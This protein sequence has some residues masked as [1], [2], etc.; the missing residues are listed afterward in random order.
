MAAVRHLGISCFQFLSKIQ[1]QI[2]LNSTSTWYRD[3]YIRPVW[4]EI[5]YSRPILGSLGYY[6]QMNPDIVAT[7][8]GL[9]LGENK[10]YEP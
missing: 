9:S 10:L 3:F 2:A 1:F 7:A 4:L 8:K 6:P 5:A